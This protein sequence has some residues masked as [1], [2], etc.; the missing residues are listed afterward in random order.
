MPYIPKTERS[1]LDPLIERLA[2]RIHKPGELTYV[3]CRLLWYLWRKDYGIN[4]NF[5]GWCWMRA[6]VEE[7][8]A[9]FRDRHI[10]VRHGGYEAVQLAK[11]GDV[12]TD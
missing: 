1:N 3:I 8:V 11:N 7:A 4:M 10:D 5:T 6:A 9:D 2:P 12:Y